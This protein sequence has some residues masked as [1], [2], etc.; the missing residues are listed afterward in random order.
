MA[1]LRILFKLIRM[2]YINV[3]EYNHMARV[4]LLK[5]TSLSLNHFA[6]LY[7]NTTIC[8]KARAQ[9]AIAQGPMTL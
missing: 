9:F 7:D 3:S 4:F 1:L 5:R 6:C 8:D 2:I